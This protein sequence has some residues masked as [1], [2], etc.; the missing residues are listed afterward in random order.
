MKKAVF[1][2]PGQGAQYVGM[3]QDLYQNDSAAKSFFDRADQILGQPISKLCFEG[4]ESELL[5][6]KNTQLAIFVTSIAALEA[7]RNQY[8]EFSLA[9]SCGLSLGEFT[10]LVALNAITFEDGLKLVQKRAELMDQAV[11]MYGSETHRFE[12]GQGGR[13]FFGRGL[14]EAEMNPLANLYI[15]MAVILLVIGSVLLLDWFGRRKDKKHSH[16]H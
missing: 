8:N 5:K 12:G 9:L 1:I 3:G 2:F 4:P 16:S 13:S 6:T 7:L 14:K 15:M 11:G 10:A